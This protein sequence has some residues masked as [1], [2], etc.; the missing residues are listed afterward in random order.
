[1][2]VNFCEK[3]CWRVKLAAVREHDPG[4][5]TPITDWLSSAEGSDTNKRSK[6]DKITPYRAKWVADLLQSIVMDTPGKSVREVLFL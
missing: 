6:G 5:D 1:M 2:Q 3:M 4:S